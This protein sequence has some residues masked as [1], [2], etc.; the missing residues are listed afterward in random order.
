MP[1]SSGARRLVV[2]RNL[3]VVSGTVDPAQV[4]SHVLGWEQL[5]DALPEK[6]RKPVFVRDITA[7]PAPAPAPAPGRSD[8]RKNS[9]RPDAT[10]SGLHASLR[11]QAA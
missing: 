5:P 4:V 7:P 10:P 11:C 9:I 2:V 8:K 3:S 1:G 6:H